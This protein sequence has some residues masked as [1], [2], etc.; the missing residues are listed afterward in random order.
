MET[1]LS[2]VYRRGNWSSE[3]LNDLPKVTCQEVGKPGFK[4]GLSSYALSFLDKK[5]LTFLSHLEK[6]SMPHFFLTEKSRASAPL[7]LFP[8]SLLSFLCRGE[9][10]PFS[11]A[12]L[13]VPTLRLLPCVSF[14][15]A[16]HWPVA[17]FRHPHLSLW[18]YS[19]T[20][21]LLRPR[22]CCGSSLH[23]PSTSLIPG[24]ANPV[25]RG[26]WPWSLLIT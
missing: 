24:D 6:S 9:A 20:S 3:R 26:I 2:H 25:T 11:K 15:T 22:A 13:S 10:M 5:L 12:E 21:C 1:F 7:C 23:C 18:S 4:Q 14:I 16:L 8:W 19:N 17:P